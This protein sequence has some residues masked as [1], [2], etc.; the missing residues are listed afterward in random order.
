M[1]KLGLVYWQYVQYEAV[2]VERSWW[3]LY[4]SA[5]FLSENCWV[6]GKCYYHAALW[7]RK[8]N[9]VW[10]CHVS[11]ASHPR[12]CW[13]K[14]YM[15]SWEPSWLQPFVPVWLFPETCRCVSWRHSWETIHQLWERSSKRDGWPKPYW[16]KHDNTAEPCLKCLNTGVLFIHFLSSPVEESPVSL[17]K[18]LGTFVPLCDAVLSPPGFL[19]WGELAW[20]HLSSDQYI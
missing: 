7:K 13:K 19:S 6:A 17:G 5:G 12:P 1:G 11:R 9:N 10:M 15:G 14:I 18:I 16:G 3:I 2:P 4:T 8:V 20:M